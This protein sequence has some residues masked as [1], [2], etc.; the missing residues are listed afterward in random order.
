M[1]GFFS[2]YEV[3][4][5]V[6][7]LMSV[8]KAAAAIVSKSNAGECICIVG[9]LC[10]PLVPAFA[11]LE[12]IFDVADCQGKAGASQEMEDIMFDER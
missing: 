1:F 4:S 9:D 6:T 12:Q 11:R 2:E 10:N 7:S 3:R 8:L 5:Q